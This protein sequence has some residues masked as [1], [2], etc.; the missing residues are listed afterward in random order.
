MKQNGG[1]RVYAN[2][3]AR[4]VA[5]TE[6]PENSN[7]CWIWTGHFSSNGYGRVAVRIPGVAHPRN[8]TA[9]RVMLEEFWEIE[10]PFDQ[11]GHLCYDTRCINPDHLEV[12]TA[13]WNCAERRG[14]HGNAKGCCIPTVFPRVDRLQAMADWAWDTP[15]IVGGDCPF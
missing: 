12:Q 8:K 14:Y 13:S 9:V 3:F 10:F 1:N 11:A 5:S 2:L 6:E 15:G 7:S 4:L